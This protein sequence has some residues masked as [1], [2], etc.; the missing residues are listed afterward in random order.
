M[1]AFGLA[2]LDPP[3]GRGLAERALAA[4]LAGGWLAPGAVVVVEEQAG[5]AF[6]LPGVFAAL[7]ARTYG[8]TQVVFG[9]VG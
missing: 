1:G 5:A 3:Y 7:D 6:A 9:R 4:A 2:F 8:D